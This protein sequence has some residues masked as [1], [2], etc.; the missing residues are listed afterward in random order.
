MGRWGKS[1]LAHLPITSYSGVHIFDAPGSTEA[2]RPAA[3][4]QEFGLVEVP[5]LFP[6]F[7][8]AP[9]QT[10]AVVRQPC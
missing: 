6:R 10:V 7:N 5:E 4:A 1:A 2:G 8:I 3:V 9:T